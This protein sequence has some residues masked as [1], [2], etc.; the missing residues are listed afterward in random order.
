MDIRF[1]SAGA[2]DLVL[3]G[4]FRAEAEKMLKELQENLPD[5]VVTD[6]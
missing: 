5:L 1:R 2:A 6:N 3:N 4:L